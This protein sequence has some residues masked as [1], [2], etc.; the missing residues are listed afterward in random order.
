MF[1]RPRLVGVRAACAE[2]GLDMPVVGELA[3]PPDICVR[4]LAALLREWVKQPTPATAVA[5]YLK[6]R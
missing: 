4:E 2:L 6:V 3:A 5:C 1:A